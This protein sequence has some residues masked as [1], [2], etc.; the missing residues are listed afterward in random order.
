MQCQ[1]F[2]VALSIPC[3]PYH[4]KAS[5]GKRL[6][7]LSELLILQI[8]ILVVI[9]MHDQPFEGLKAVREDDPA[10]QPRK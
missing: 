7:L 10:C 6:N 1:R 3:A 9:A 8:D 5:H 4:Y 2:H